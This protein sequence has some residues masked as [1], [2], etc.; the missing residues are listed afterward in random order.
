MSDNE[1]YEDED[2][3]KGKDLHLEALERFDAV[4]EQ[5]R[6]AREQCLQD[7]RFCLIAGAQWEGNLSLQF[8]NKPMLEINKVQLALVRIINEY[9]NNRIT[10]NFTSKD[11]ADNDDLADVCNDLYRATEK[12]SISTEAYD[13]GFEEGC[14]GGFGAWRYRTQYIDESD[15]ENDEQEILIEPIFDADQSVFF[16]PK[17]KRQDKSDADYC[18][19]INP[20][21]LEEY[22]DE[23]GDEDIT[24][25]DKVNYGVDYDWVCDKDTVYVAEYFVKEKVTETYYIY[26]TISGKEE[27]YYK[28]ELTAEKK[29]ILAAVGSVFDRK[30]DIKKQKIRKYILSGSKTLEDCGYIAG[31]EIPIT[32][33]YGKRAVINGIERIMGEV[34]FAK[35]PQRVR[36]MLY[37]KIAEISAS[38]SVEKPIFTPEQIAG[39]TTRWNEDNV[40]N[41]AYQ[42]INPI[43][44]IN[45]NSVAQPPVGYT[46]SPQ[47]PPAVAALLTISEEDIKDLLGNRQKGDEIVSNISQGAIELIQNRLDMQSFIYMSNFAKAMARGGKIW[48]SMAKDI[49]IEEGRRMKT[50]KEN[51]TVDSVVLL[52]KMQDKNGRQYFAND[53]SKANFD[54]DVNIGATTSSKKSATVRALS[55]MLALTENPETKD[56]ISTMI[57]LNMEGDGIG[58]IKEYFKMKLVRMG[59]IKPND[60]QKE[61][62]SKEQESQQPSAQE[63]YLIASAKEN[64]AQAVKAAADT[65]LSLAKAEKEKADT[66]K[67]MT[68]INQG[69]FYGKG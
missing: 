42:L 62:L 43:T 13:N 54:V 59:V 11:G 68:E 32:I 48:L 5:S 67:T 56:I 65:E 17:S 21:T 46:K 44:D 53:L 49:Y 63:N 40:Q 64:E 41:Y 45:G 1:K 30:R 36:N 28:D 52:E 57:L 20:M 3:S 9:R 38:S 35:D 22:K 50:I 14:T 26:K 61:I 10:V 19:L 4:Y 2:E 8:E 55:Q 24:S 16:D 15:P 7:R 33:F 37:S 69:G 23:Y 47:I 66:I 39:H 60:F 51:G 31:S 29:Q 58:D 6:D 25:W 27:R 34:R 18:F 12:K